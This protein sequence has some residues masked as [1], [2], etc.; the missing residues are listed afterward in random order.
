[1]KTLMFVAAA[2][3]AGP[4][5][6]KEFSNMDTN[7]DG[8]VTAAEHAA[9][10]KAMFDIMDGDRDGKVMPN[11]M[12]AAHK[13]ITGQAA[14]PSD[15]S[16]ADKIKVV[17]G[18]GDGILTADEHARASAAMFTRMDR[19]KDGQLTKEEMA[20]GHAAMMVK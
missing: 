8:K 3:L 13:A 12:A 14:R 19:N 4:E 2:L 18:N 16:A 20:A 7:Q 10:A 1:M 17:D 11:E 15:M 9:G 5:V 6:G